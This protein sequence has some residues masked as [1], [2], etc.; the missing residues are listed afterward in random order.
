MWRLINPIRRRLEERLDQAWT[1]ARWK[2]ASRLAVVPFDGRP[3]FALLTVNRSTT[4]Y[5]KLMLL[6]LCQQNRLDLVRRIVICDNH[7]RDGGAPFV[8][9]LGARVAQIEVVENRHFLNHARGMRRCIATLTRSESKKTGSGQANVLLCCDTDVVFRDPNT[10]ADL[11]DLIVTQ[12]ADV[13]GELRE[14]LFSWPEAQA[15]FLAVR[16]ECYWRR[17]TVPWVNHGSPAY[18]L[19]RSVWRAGG[20]LVHFPSNQGGYVL[21]RGRA[22]VAALQTYAPGSS[23]GGVTSTEP[24]FMGVPD[25]ARIWKEIESRYAALLD[26]LAEDRLLDVLAGR[27]GR[28][29]VGAE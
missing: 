16:T 2:L 29:S 25:G 15:S 22:S 21:H 1:L 5:L 9:R 12:Q 10:L 17:Q 11:A 18:W 19:Q 24:H 4:R 6:T 20:R 23:Y 7:S 28:L 27:L 8:R 13:A 14:G 26:P 3:R